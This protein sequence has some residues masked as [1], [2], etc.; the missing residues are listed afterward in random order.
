MLLVVVGGSGRGIGEVEGGPGKGIGDE[1]CG[2]GSGSGMGEELFGGGVFSRC[3]GL[4]DLVAVEE[5]GSG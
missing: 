5:G 1:G 2:G 3:L 4:C